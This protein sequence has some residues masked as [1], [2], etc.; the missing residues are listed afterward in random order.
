[1][2]LRCLVRMPQ[3]FLSLLHHGHSPHRS[4]TRLAF[5]DRAEKCSPRRLQPRHAGQAH[6][7]HSPAGRGACA[8][9]RRRVR[10]PARPHPSAGLRESAQPRGDEP[11][12]RSRRGPPAHG[13]AHDQDLAGRRKAHEPRIRRGGLVARRSGNA[14]GRRHDDVGPLLLP[15]LCGP[16]PSSRGTA[17]RRVGLHHRLSLGL[18]QKRRRILRKNGGHDSGRTRR[19][20]PPRHGNGGPARSL[21]GVGRFASPLRGNLRALQPARSHARA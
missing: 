12:A 14:L 6:R 20:R 3:R 11:R 16:R 19:G 9:R 17:R 10:S 5:A 4:R 13:L 2:A 18:R 7:S 8:L 15:A 21:H 1:M